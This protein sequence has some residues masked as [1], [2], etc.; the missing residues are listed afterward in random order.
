MTNQKSL[1]IIKIQEQTDTDFLR[2]YLRQ[3]ECEILRLACDFGENYDEDYDED[4]MGISILRNED[5]ILEQVEIRCTLLNRM[6]ELNYSET[7]FRDLEITNKRLLQ[8]EAKVLEIHKNGIKQLTTIQPFFSLSSSLTYRHDA[9]NPKL[10]IREDDGFY[11]SQWNDMIEILDM[12]GS[13]SMTDNLYS[14]YGDSSDSYTYK[15]PC[16]IDLVLPK[17]ILF[18]YSFC[19][20]C[21]SQ[22]Y[23]IPDI[24]R[25]TTYHICQEVF[26][27]QLISLD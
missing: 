23:S 20:L 25:M 19:E 15:E 21:N 12:I 6:F 7:Y 5:E 17:E 4:N 16:E 18:C 1:E 26:M 22:Y 24:M 11:G 3:C 10:I 2:R 9:Q 27:D 8:M 13:V 14:C